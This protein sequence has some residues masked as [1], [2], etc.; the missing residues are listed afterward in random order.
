MRLRAGLPSL[1]RVLG[2]RGFSTAAFVGNWTLRDK[3]S[4]LGEHFHTYRQMPAAS[5][6]WC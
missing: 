3:I 2:Q 1:A 6:G 4:G 5:A